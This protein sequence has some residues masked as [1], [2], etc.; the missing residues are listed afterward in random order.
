MDNFINYIRA[1]G[2]LTDNFHF[3]CCTEDI[4]DASSYQRMIVSN[5]HSYCSGNHTVR[6]PFIPIAGYH[7][8]DRMTVVHPTALL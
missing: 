2:C 6:I 4:P 3:R 1:V 5:Q 8:T 7:R